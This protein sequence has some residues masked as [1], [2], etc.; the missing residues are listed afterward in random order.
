MPC[1][2]QGRNLDNFSEDFIMHNPKAFLFIAVVLAMVSIARADLT[3]TVNGL[4]TTSKPLE[5]KGKDNL[6]IAIAG[7]SDIRAQD[8]SVTCDAA[9]LEPLTK[10]DKYLFT[11][12]DESNVDT[13]RLNVGEAVVYRLTLFYIPESDTVIVFGVDKEALVLLEPE[14]ELGPEQQVFASQGAEP[15]KSYFASMSGGGTSEIDSF[16]EP[17]SY[18]DLNSDKIVNFFDFAIFA[19]DWLKSGSGLAGDFDNSGAVDTNDLATFA[20]FWLNGPHPLDVFESFKAAL[21]IGDVNEAVSYF[22]EVSAE[23]YRQLLGQLRP[24]FTQMV[25]DM[26][27]LIFIEQNEEMVYYD[28]LREED[29]EIYAYPVIF[30]NEEDGRWKIYDF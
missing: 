5:I 14:S 17:N 19:G 28:L 16:P 23:N 2:I 7:Q 21:A 26:G 9:K 24:Y 10:P 30:V 27:E 18:P 29:G 11:F 1:D 12:L 3:L 15:E 4:D 6:V 20:F 13:V 22:A 8:I 25:N